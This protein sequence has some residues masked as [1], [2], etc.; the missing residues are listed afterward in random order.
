MIAIQGVVVLRECLLPNTWLC[1]PYRGVCISYIQS[2]LL[3][4]YVI[5]RYPAPN[6]WYQF[7]SLIRNWFSLH[8]IDEYH[9]NNDIDLCGLLTFTSQ[10]SHNPQGNQHIVES[11]V[12]GLRIWGSVRHKELIWMSETCSYRGGPRI[13]KGVGQS[14]ISVTWGKMEL[15]KKDGAGKKYGSGGPLPLP[16][17]PLHP[18]VG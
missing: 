9:R 10:D 16:P 4:S 7:H 13:F 2:S 8:I 3:R 11:G 12:L 17:P 18:P 1:L 15:G 14:N 5:Q 6:T